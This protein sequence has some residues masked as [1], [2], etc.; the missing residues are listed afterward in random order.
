M[1]N[2]WGKGYVVMMK[3][4]FKTVDSLIIQL[5][6]KKMRVNVQVFLEHAQSMFL[7]T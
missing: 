6:Q 4:F 3:T 7:T 5:I 2:M 1:Q